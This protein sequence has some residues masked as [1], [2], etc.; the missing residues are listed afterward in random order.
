MQPY[1]ADYYRSLRDGARRSAEVVVP[2]V[3]RLGRP[4]SVVDVGCGV[5]TWLAVFRE[6]G[7]EDICGVDG[8][9]VDREQLEIPPSYFLPWDLTRPLR[10]GRRFDL[11]VS[12]EVAEHLP[13]ECA[14]GFVGSLTDVAPLVLFSAAVP[15]QG[16]QQHINEQWPAYWARLFA[17]RGYLP[18][19][20]LRRRLWEDERVEWWYAQ[21]VLLFAERD[22]L[23]ARP[24]LRREYELAGGTAPALVHPKRYLEWV[25]WG[26][27][28]SR[29]G[30]EG[31]PGPAGEGV[32]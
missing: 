15:F 7:V 30:Y 28:L 20:C 25:E 29:R 1:T 16:G 9:Y 10:L 6:L 21:N 32:A 5:G 14:E 11:A 13:A 4:R 19:D 17:A 3:L 26:L 24:N 8:D 27:A 2:V 12:L 22:S 23:E 18:V 31:D